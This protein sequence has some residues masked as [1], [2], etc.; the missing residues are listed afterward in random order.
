M[1]VL[2]RYLLVVCCVTMFSVAGRAQNTSIVIPAGTPEDKDLATIS[3]ESDAQKRI[4]AYEDFLKK[5]S[6]NKPAVAYAEWQLSQQYLA[7]GDASKAM[8][9]GEKALQ[10]YPNNLDIIMSQASVAQA[11]K[12]NSKVVDYAVQGA[13]VYGS[14]AK[15]PKP[16]DMSDAEFAGKIKSEQS[17]AQNDYDFLETSAYDAIASEQ[18]P[19]KRMTEIEKFTPAFSKSKYE[20]QVSQLALY[21]LRQLNQPQRLEAYGEK[22]L[23]ANPDSIPTL[24]M[25]GDAYAASPKDATK[26]ATYANKVITLVGPSPDT[27]ETKSYAGLAHVTLGRAELNQEKLVPAVTDLKAAVTLLQDD[28]ADQQQALF[29]LGYAYAKQNH[30]ADALASLQKAAAIDG[31]YAAPAKDMLAK[32]NAAAPAKK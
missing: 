24:L 22:T 2:H 8:E 29:Y 26:A 31:P 13:N 10:A 17:A 9:W 16:A 6:D 19:N 23:A 18:D 1:R 20:A 32:I 14:I 30:K 11:M 3:A 27:K 5:Y 15:Q 21:S 4:A 28:P 7:A 25:M 12:D